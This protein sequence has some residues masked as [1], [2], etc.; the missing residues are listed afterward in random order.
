MKVEASEAGGGAGARPS[1][2]A[3]WT[4]ARAMRAT[5]SATKRLTFTAS[6]VISLAQRQTQTILFT[7]PASGV[8]LRERERGDCGGE[9]RQCLG[10][11]H[12]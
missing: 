3:S 2:A 4:V 1:A 12:I 6:I 7:S 5:T 9:E 8:A 11:V 10:A